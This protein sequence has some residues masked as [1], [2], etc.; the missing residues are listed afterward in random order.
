MALKTRTRLVVLFVSGKAYRQAIGVKLIALLLLASAKPRSAITMAPKIPEQLVS[1]LPLILGRRAGR[2]SPGRRN[3]C[4]DFA[5]GNRYKLM[6][7]GATVNERGTSPIGIS[8]GSTCATCPTRLAASRLFAVICQSVDGF[9]TFMPKTL[10]SNF[11]SDSVAF[12]TATAKE[13][14]VRR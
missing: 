9:A 3:Y 6:L 11:C 4:A 7:I 2:F 8:F 14:A 12:T 13:L 1:P 10:T 5:T